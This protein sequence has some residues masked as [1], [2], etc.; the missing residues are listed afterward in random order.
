MTQKQQA[1]PLEWNWVDFHNMKVLAIE[2]KNYAGGEM[3]TVTLAPP[4]SNYK[5]VCRA[6][7]DVAR[8]IKEN[9]IKEGSTL[10]IRT[11][12]SWYKGESGR[13][14]DS[15]KIKT[16]LP[17]KPAEYWNAV[18]LFNM[19]VLSAE[20]KEFSRGE[21]CSVAL[22][23]PHF[24]HKFV[25]HA[26]DG[27]AREINGL[28][29]EEGSSLSVKTELSWY[30]SGS[31]RCLDSYKIKKVLNGA[32]VSTSA[33]AAKSPAPEAASKEEKDEPAKRNI[34]PASQRVIEMMLSKAT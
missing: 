14:L 10:T 30:K 17:N 4:T 21:M 3:C 13:W 34:A 18:W 20:K 19:K 1:Q 12:L 6:F 33:P 32:R 25:C 31:G 11:V 9:K 26:F 15:Y 8:K 2:Y 22:T 5:F 23:P 29:L 24:N 28:N 7:D 16:I 27:V